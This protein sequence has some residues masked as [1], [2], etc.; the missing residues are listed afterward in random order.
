MRFC[1]A[2]PKTNFALFYAL[3]SLNAAHCE[4]HEAQGCV[5]VLPVLKHISLYFMLYFPSMLHIV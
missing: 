1:A 2:C 5:F 4:V 3:L